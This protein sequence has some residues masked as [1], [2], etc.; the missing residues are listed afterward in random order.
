M[1]PA[2]LAA[3]DQWDMALE[4]SKYR[5]ETDRFVAGYTRRITKAV[6]LWAGM[7]GDAVVHGIV[8]GSVKSHCAHIGYGPRPVYLFLRFPGELY[9]QKEATMIYDLWM[10][11]EVAK[12]CDVCGEPSKK[13]KRFHASHHYLMLSGWICEGCIDL[14]AK[15][16]SV[17]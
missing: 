10:R 5:T 4:E 12:V 13:L 2:R 14:G 6:D 3:Q 11:K 1:N 7:A 9:C 15:L 16:E 8:E 17:E